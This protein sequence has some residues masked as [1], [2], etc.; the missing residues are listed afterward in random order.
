MIKIPSVP[1]L[2]KHFSRHSPIRPLHQLLEAG[3]PE[4]EREAGDTTAPE[5]TRLLRNS[6]RTHSSP[7]VQR[8]FQ[9]SS[10][11]V[12]EII[13]TDA[14]LLLPGGWGGHKPTLRVVTG[15]LVCCG[16]SC[17]P[18]CGTFCANTRTGLGKLGLWSPYWGACSGS[19]PVSPPTLSGG[20]PLKQALAQ[21]KQELDKRWQES[22]RRRDSR[23][24][25]SYFCVFAQADHYT[26]RPR[27]SPRC[28]F[29]PSLSCPD[30]VCDATSFMST[31]DLPEIVLGALCAPNSHRIS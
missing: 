21:E 14:L 31:T 17:F 18:G 11:G 30:G 4:K 27:L 26:L 8:S 25:Q 16:T 2:T 10:P 6:S 19:L 13:P 9:D 29:R 22:G 1:E 3:R 24:M 23:A 7:G 12:Q 15:C 28:L 20:R 5:F